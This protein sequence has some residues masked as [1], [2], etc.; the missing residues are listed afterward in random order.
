M[1]YT[2][3]NRDHSA[4]LTIDVQNDF[5]L[6]GAPAEIPG[7]LEVLPAIRDLVRAFRENEIPIVHVVRLYEPDGSNAELCRRGLLEQ[8]K[9]MVTP[10]S[11]GAELAADLKP[12]RDLRLNPPLLLSGALQEIG[13]REWI[14]Y[15]PRWGAFYK[16]SLESH[17][18]T[19]DVD[20]LV[21]AGCNFPNC[22]RTSIYEASERDF[23]IVLVTDAVSGLYDQGIKEMANI[24]VNLMT[25]AQCGAVINAE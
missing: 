14:I 10:G 1:D 23:K 22:P 13:K 18:R 2:A 11:S 9:P 25:A 24:G 17:L 8:G 16:T 5:V 20:T 4:L 7:S 21:F 15:K 6:P 3:P 19:L 12:N